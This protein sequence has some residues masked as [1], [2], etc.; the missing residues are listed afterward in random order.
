M[1]EQ[2]I[3]SR[4]DDHEPELDSREL[5][6]KTTNFIQNDLLL[7]LLYFGLILFLPLA[8]WNHVDHTLT[9]AWQGCMIAISAARWVCRLTIINNNQAFWNGT[10][11]FLTLLDGL[12]WG[13]ATALLF[14]VD[15]TLAISLTTLLLIGVGGLGAV[16]YSARMVI[17]IPYL[18]CVTLPYI[19]RLYQ[20]GGNT[21]FIIASSFSLL[22]IM[23][24]FTTDRLNINLT[25]AL[26]NN[27][28]DDETSPLEETQNY[29]KNLEN[30]IIR[31][32]QE[33]EEVHQIISRCSDDLY[34][35]AGTS[36][37]VLSDLELLK[38]TRLDQHQTKLI[39]K[40]E[41]NARHLSD[42]LNESD[43]TDDNIHNN[44]DLKVSSNTEII[45]V[46]HSDNSRVLV[47]DVDRHE[48]ENIESCVRDLNLDCQNVENVPAALAVL[49]EAQ[50][51]G[52]HFDF[53]IANMWM[54]EM[55][56]LSFAECLQ[57][58]PEFQKIKIILIS[59]GELPSDKKLQKAGVNMM[60]NKPVVAK[61]LSHA[62]NILTGK[63]TSTLPA[64]I[65]ALID[66]A[67]RIS[68]P[69][70]EIDNQNTQTS[71]IIDRYVIDGLRSSTSTNFI[72]IINEFLEEA[73]Q[74]IEQAKTA[75]GK[76]DNAE[77]KKAI[78]ELGSRSIHM[79]AIGLVDSARKIEETID[80]HGI[81]N[82][83]GMIQSI[84]AKF[85]QVESALLAELTN[86]IIFSNELKH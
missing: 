69:A 40:I 58:D 14:P 66:D 49:C 35:L 72:E 42:T 86:G 67:V 44:N 4:E 43:E 38:Q 37:N 45:P 64:S 53:I 74:L 80:N 65:E 68:I 73:P 19:A 28:Q 12:G 27:R 46:E 22:I 16:S 84:D 82:V 15:S 18:L 5:A 57:D 75:Y 63:K 13:L 33:L 20:D 62:I 81:E 23:F 48:V 34:R 51:N 60:I 17:A 85:I 78:R 41:K 26:R 55:D 9:Y 83:M 59:S 50:A 1:S 30:Q 47:V 21:E 54:S 70:S 77:I 8:I 76:K 2:T 61:E 10:L 11:I 25:S 29:S 3:D 56:G 7:S 39:Q 32:S 36:I 71:T 6:F 79:G 24:S 52:Q 31:N